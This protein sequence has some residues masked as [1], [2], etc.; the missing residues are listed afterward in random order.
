VSEALEH[1]I[2]RA[3]LGKDPLDADLAR[4]LARHAVDA[5]DAEAILAAPRRLGL[6]RRLVRNNVTSVVG[7]ML[8]RTRARV[9]HAAPGAFDETI[10]DFL[11]ARGPRTPH[12]RDVPGELL[13]WASPRWRAD[14]RLP[15]WI[16]D[17]AELELVE[18]TMGC[19]PRAA[20]PPPLADPAP[21]LPLVFAE[22]R[23][24]LRLAWAVHEVAADDVAQAPEE[25]SVTLLAYRDREHCVRFLDLTP[26]AAAILVE[27][28]G[29]RPLADAVVAACRDQGVA[30]SGDVLAGAARLLADLGERGVLLGARARP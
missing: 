19:A 2:A 22:P 8:E 4:T 14:A 3:C 25:R 9:E 15:A 29:G 7:S 28:L 1:M 23:A 27:L 20:T 11:D 26:V 16:L 21:D 6:Y 5:E 30:A 18:F 12:L 13:A 24:L 10:A 17:Y